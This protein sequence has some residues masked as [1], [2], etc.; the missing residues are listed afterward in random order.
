MNHDTK[1]GYKEVSKSYLFAAIW[2]IAINE[3][4][5]ECVCWEMDKILDNDI[6][7]K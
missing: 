4:I 5:S 1:N 6:A 2:T 3:D 7:W